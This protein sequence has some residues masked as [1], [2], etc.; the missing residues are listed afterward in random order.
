MRLHILVFVGMLLAGIKAASASEIVAWKVPLSSFTRCEW[1]PANQKRLAAAPAASP[2]FR[3]GDELWD[4]TKQPSL[5]L[6]PL[7]D[8]ISLEWAVWNASSGTLVTKSDWNGIGKLYQQLGIERLP[9]QCRLK[10]EVFEVP[11]SGAPLAEGAKAAAVMSWVARPGT[12]SEAQR[13][14]KAGMLQAS[15]EPTF[16]ESEAWIELRVDASCTLPAQPALNVKTGLTLKSGDGIW[17]ARDFDG[18]AGIDLKLTASIETMEGC[19]PSEVVKIQKGDQSASLLTRFQ[20]FGRSRIGEKGW[21]IAKHVPRR[22][23]EQIF[24][25][26][27]VNPGADPF[28]PAPTMP[29]EKIKEKPFA[30]IQPPDELKSKG[31][32]AVWEIKQELKNMGLKLEDSRDFAGYDPFTEACFL[33]SESE[34]DLD[35]F[36]A[37]FPGGC[38]RTPKIMILTLEG[39]GQ[40]RLSTRSGEAG[41]MTRGDKGQ[42]PRR[43]VKSEATFGEGDDVI[44]L[45][46]QLEDRTKPDAFMFLNAT[47]LLRVA[48]FVDLFSAEQA[49]TSPSFLRAKVEVYSSPNAGE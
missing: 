46:L 13:Q 45:P 31:L 33:F 32:P 29:P 48:T 49:K 24:S 10:L 3:P 25:P 9:K 26:I 17:L 16:D 35:L 8:D 2:F 44:E 43:L 30:L 14:T 20:G 12:K 39:Y 7:S 40:S 36:E 11:A 42:P 15:V 22:L 47:H 18:H 41:S 1:I 4:L 5:Q 38:R 37:L 34:L 19:P 28:A 6:P 21:L 27:A 23:I